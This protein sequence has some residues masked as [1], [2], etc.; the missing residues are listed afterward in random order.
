MKKSLTCAILALTLAFTLAA[1]A[2]GAGYTAA[3]LGLAAEGVFNFNGYLNIGIPTEEGGYAISDLLLDPAG[4]A[5]FTWGNE[6]TWISGDGHYLARNKLYD[7][8][9]N[10]VLELDLNKIANGGEVHAVVAENGVIAIVAS[11]L[12]LL[13][14]SGNVTGRYTPD[15]YGFDVNAYSG[16][17][18]IGQGGLI[19]VWLGLPDAEYGDYKFVVLD[20]TGEVLADL[21]GTFS[22]VGAFC[23]G[24]AWAFIPDGEGWF[25]THYID[26]TGKIQ[27]TADADSA[28]EF[29]GGH[30]AVGVITADDFY[31]YGVIDKSGKLVI[32]PQYEELRVLGDVFMAKKDGKYGYIDAANTVLVPFEYSDITVYKNGVGYG[33]KDGEVYAIRLTGE[34]VPTPWAAGQVDAAIAAGLVPENLQKNYTSPVTRGDAAQMFIN[35]IEQSSG[36]TIDAFL[37]EKDVTYDAGAFTDTIEKSVFAANALGIINGVGGGK[38]NPAGTL[39]RAQAA[40]IINRTALVLGVKTAGYTHEFTDVSGHWADAELGWPSHAGVINGTGGGKFTPDG[41]LTVEQA[42]VIAYRAFQSFKG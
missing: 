19:T 5:V 25:T 35:L 4:K 17:V 7:N 42:I 30:A 26:K 1:S 24:L 34:D 21:G 22:N 12:I 10:L 20:V 33:V 15:E 40:A 18:F 32:A 31:R 8:D 2:L 9:F 36:M 41:Q 38:F 29:S 23:D 37:E 3:P 39:T 11:E 13:D 28:D 14:Y 27:I 6:L 16:G